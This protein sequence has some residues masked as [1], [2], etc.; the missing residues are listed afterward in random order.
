MSDVEEAELDG[1]SVDV[2]PSGA[3]FIGFENLVV[4]EDE[5]ELNTVAGIDDEFFVI[6]V[7]GVEESDEC[8]IGGEGVDE[9]FLT[10]LMFIGPEKI[11]WSDFDFE[12]D[13]DGFR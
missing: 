3:A 5:Y 10:P 1:V 9:G 8:D 2:E 7:V 11:E 4:G 12:S 6:F 13:D